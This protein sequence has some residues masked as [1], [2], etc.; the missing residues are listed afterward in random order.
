MSVKC[1]HEFKLCALTS[2]SRLSA[3][4]SRQSPAVVSHSV[5]CDGGTLAS[6]L[7][8]SACSE[9][10]FSRRRCT[11]APSA[12]GDAAPPH[13]EHNPSTANPSQVAFMPTFSTAAPHHS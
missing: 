4:C 5:R 7:L 13:P 8:L 11:S 2:L 9:A 1:S 10:T 12:V 6:F 3:T